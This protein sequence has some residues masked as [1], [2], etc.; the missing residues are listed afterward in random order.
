MTF[1][2]RRD[3]RRR[4]ERLST[5][6]ENSGRLFAAYHRQRLGAAGIP[7]TAGVRI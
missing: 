5:V 1:V 6:A 2:K 7:R 4:N 3:Q